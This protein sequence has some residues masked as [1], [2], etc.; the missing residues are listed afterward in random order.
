MRLVQKI[1]TKR[2]H[3]DL[4]GIWL[5]CNAC[6]NISCGYQIGKVECL[7]LKPDKLSAQNNLERARKLAAGN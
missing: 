4:A 2:K 3:P 1:I 5:S 7:E 6:L